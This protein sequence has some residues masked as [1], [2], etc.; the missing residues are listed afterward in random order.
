MNVSG[1]NT[2]SN[3]YK[4][5]NTLISYFPNYNNTASDETNISRAS[6]GSTETPY[7]TNILNSP[8]KSIFYKYSPKIY[9]YPY[10]Y[11][12]NFPNYSYSTI[13]HTFYNHTITPG[14]VRIAAILIGGGGSGGGGSQYSNGGHGAA[15]GSGASGQ[16]VIFSKNSPPTY[17]SIG[18]GNGGAPSTGNNGGYPYQIFN[19]PA[20]TGGFDTTISDGFG[21]FGGLPEIQANG[22]G[23]GG[24]VLSGS[25][26]T[27]GAAGTGDTS[28]NTYLSNTY[29]SNVILFNSG[30]NGN[31]GSNQ[32]ATQSPGGAETPINYTNINN[33]F[34]STTFNTV[35]TTAYNITTS[36]YGLGGQGG[37]GEGT[38]NNTGG[39]RPGYNGNPGLVVLFEYFIL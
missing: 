5:S 1:Q 22:G 29:L 31:A 38:N 32:L 20:N 27:G 13:D 18:V 23:A 10:G 14:T 15:G 11:N 4:V 12:V 9:V 30:V 26:T 17:L 24:A 35:N 8:S 28:M 33:Y 2:T 21:G 36:K 7:I 6:Y 16:V 25:A 37:Y 39:A 3:D 19:D 34:T